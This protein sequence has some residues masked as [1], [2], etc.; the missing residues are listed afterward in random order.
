M[1]RRLLLAAMLLAAMAVSAFSGLES[2]PYTRLHPQ[3][4]RTAEIRAVWE[5]SGKG[6]YPG[7]WPRTFRVLKAN[8][9]TDLFVNVGGID[10]AHYASRVLPRSY[11]FR[12]A[13]DQLAACLAAATARWPFTARNMSRQAARTAATAA[14]AGA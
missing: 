3:P 12:T 5:Q 8:G 1:A 11:L 2:H 7:D 13:G 6:L 4:A 10:F 9:I 14:A